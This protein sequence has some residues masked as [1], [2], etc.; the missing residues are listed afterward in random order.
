MQRQDYERAASNYFSQDPEGKSN[1]LK[2]YSATILQQVTDEMQRTTLPTITGARVTTAKLIR[3]RKLIRTDG[4]T[5][6][7]DRLEAIAVAEANLKVVIGEV[8]ATP[9]SREELGYFSSLSQRELSQLYYGEDG[10]AL[11]EFAIRYR[12][13]NREFMFQIPSRP[14]AQQESEQGGDVELTAA[15]YHALPAAEL[16]RRLRNPQFAAAVERLAQRGEI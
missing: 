9:L 15:Q 11:N 7:D 16:Q 10:S 12:R 14:A 13:A 5:D 2:F 8:D 4:K 3:E 6:A 1:F